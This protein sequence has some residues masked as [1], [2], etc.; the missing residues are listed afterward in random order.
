MAVKVLRT[1]QCFIDFVEILHKFISYNFYWS[2]IFQIM[3]HN[4]TCISKAI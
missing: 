3:I 1:T 2:Y 4:K